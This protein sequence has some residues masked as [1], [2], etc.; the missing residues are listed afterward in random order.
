MFMGAMIMGPLAAFCMKKVDQQLEGHIKPGLEMLVN[1]FSMGFLGI[2][3][4]LIAYFAIGP[5]VSV[6]TGIL[7]AGVNWIIANNLIPFSSL[8]IE[9]AKVLFLNNAINH[10]ILSPIGI[11]QAA[12]A[13]KS[14]LFL[15]EPNPGPGLG[16]L[17][18][19]SIFG[20]GTA[21]STAP[22][23]AIIHCIGG[24]HEPYFPYILMK[25]QM[26]IAP[27]IGAVC[28]N[29]IF[30]SFNVG[31][32][33][34]ASPGSFF[35]IL[36]VA[37]RQDWL[38][39]LAGIF[40]ATAVSF[41]IGSF[42]LKVSYKREDAKGIK[43]DDLSKAIAAK[44]A[45]KLEG[46]EL[47]NNGTV[48]IGVNDAVE[49]TNKNIK[50]IYVACDAGM[51]SSVMGASILKKKIKEAGLN[52][53]V[54]HS[55]ITQVPENAEVIVTHESLTQRAASVRPTAMH[56]SIDNFLASPKYDEI[57]NALKIA[58]NLR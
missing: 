25:P 18:A 49:F 58:A 21:K 42:I 32:V 29:F 55:P 8:F 14:I 40:L 33:A 4:V 30:T 3:L 56:I 12:S 10:G 53:E 52:V 51:G 26:I 38:P 44:D 34:T 35:S 27:M 17:L 2:L 7:S 54:E 48:I 31:L 57:V 41:A 13:G 11:T 16:V 46:T 45:M 22:G 47:T 5:F 39:I 6:I 24:I 28:G 20:R 19:Y 37:P 9:P 1:N 36:A 50:K 43:N 15:L 23:V